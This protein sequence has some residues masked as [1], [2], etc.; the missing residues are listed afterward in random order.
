MA[1]LGI[2]GAFVGVWV[3]SRNTGLS[4][5]WLGPETEP[6]PI[7]LNLLPLVAPLALTAMGLRHLR[8]LPWAGL[9]GAALCA[10]FAIGD[11]GRVNGY[12]VV[13]FTLAAGGL[14]VS[15]ASFTGMYRTA[16]R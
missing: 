15:V 2:A 10:I 3:S 14:L 9:G 12:A 5:W 16:S 13:E 11:V 6:R 1:W 4:T 8:W 7:L